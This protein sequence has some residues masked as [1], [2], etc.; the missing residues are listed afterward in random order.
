MAKVMV[1]GATGLVGENI[2]RAF[3]DAG[4]TVR[5]SDRPSSNFSELKKL[6]V[7]IVPAEINDSAAVEKTVEGMDKVIHVAGIFDF[8]FPKKTLN[9]VNHLGVRTICEAV[10]KKAPNIDRFVQVSTV[11]TYGKPATNPCK[12]D[13]PKNPRNNYEKAKYLGELAAFEYH[14]K[15]GLPVTAIRPTLIYGPKSRYGHSIF[16]A[17]MSM[18][19]SR[20]VE[21][22]TSMK[23]GPMNHHIHVEDIARAALLVSEADGAVGNRFNAV[24]TNPVDGPTFVR[25]MAEPLGF[26]VKEVL[27]YSPGLTAVFAALMGVT[28]LFLY[29]AINRV[30]AKRW[31][32]VK[33]RHGL[34]DDLRPRLDRD[35]MGYFTADHVYDF[36]SLQKLGMEWKHPDF[37]QGI[38]E[39]I[40]W[41]KEHEWIP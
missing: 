31:D 16:I 9:E 24:D 1:N 22:L 4:H 7:E 39:T 25:A 10:M 40:E 19:R 2:V 11:G 38:K 33:E 32:K 20:G 12:E 34:S 15:H 29:N 26:K 37:V 36:T 27:P 28:P 13:D 8:S 30:L 35:W 41:Y 23:A 5:V 17:I 3:L 18:I 21:E 6:G 14:E